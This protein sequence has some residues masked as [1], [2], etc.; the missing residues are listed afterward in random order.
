MPKLT[1]S[2]QPY[3]TRLLPGWKRGRLRRQHASKALLGLLMK[4]ARKK[5]KKTTRFF[6]EAYVANTTP[7][8]EGHYGSFK[9]LTNPRFVGAKPFPAGPA[10]HLREALQRHFGE[11]RLRRLQQTARQLHHIRH[12]ALKGK[13]PTAPDLWLVDRRGRHRFIEVKLPGDS[14]APHQIAGMAAIACILN[15]SVEVIELRNEQRLF[16]DLCQTMTDV[17]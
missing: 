17:E 10:E 12:K 4:K 3:D 5:T 14:M 6:G 11:R 13:L 7:H 8:Q 16:K 9:W 1:V 2:S 15:A